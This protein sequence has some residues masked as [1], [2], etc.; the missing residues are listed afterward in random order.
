M[1]TTAAWC[2]E[3]SL[4]SEETYELHSY[5]CKIVIEAKT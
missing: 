2:T 4:G 5:S 1:D 3:G